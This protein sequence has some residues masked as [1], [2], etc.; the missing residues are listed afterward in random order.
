[1]SDPIIGHRL[2]VDGVTRSVYVDTTVPPPADPAD[3]RQY[4]ID[5]DTGEPC[6]ASGSGQMKREHALPTTS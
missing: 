5:K 2:F 3:E 6:T 4:V 1:M